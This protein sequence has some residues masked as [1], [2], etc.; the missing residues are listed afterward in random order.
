MPRGLDAKV[1]EQFRLGQRPLNRF[2]Q[3][4]LD[5]QQATDGVP[6]HLGNFD[7]DF[8]EGGRFDVPDGF[9]EV[10]HADLHLLE[11]LG[12]ERLLVEVDFGRYFARHAWRPRGQG[13]RGQHRQTVGVVEDPSNVEVVG[14]GHLA[15][16]NVHDFTSALSV[17]NANLDFTVKAA[18]PSQSGVKASRRLVA[19]MTTTLSR[20]CMP[21][22]RV[23]I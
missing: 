8:T 3:T 4:V 13:R 9:L 10:V 15:G 18:G 19:P 20:P 2:L 14:D 17:G 21:S 16:V 7:V 1:L 22:M 23:S 5:L 6:A 12:R 11:H